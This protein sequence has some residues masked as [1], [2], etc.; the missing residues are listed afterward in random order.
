MNIIL[1]NRSKIKQ[2]DGVPTYHRS[3]NEIGFGREIRLK[4]D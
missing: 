3:R 2:L 4:I 1:F